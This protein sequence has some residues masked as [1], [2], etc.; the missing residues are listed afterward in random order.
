M[1][2][3]LIRQLLLIG[4]LAIV[5]IVVLQAYLVLKNYE[6]QDDE[7]HL[8]ASTALRTVAERIGSLY[9]V[10][11]PKKDLITR[12][13]SNL[14]AVNVNSEIDANVLEDYLIQEFEKH[15][16]ETDFEYAVYD[17]QSDS[18]VYGNYCNL[19]DTKGTDLPIRELP[20]YQEL[21]YYFVVRFPSRQSFLLNNMWQTIL[22]SAIALLAVL[23]FIYAIMIIMRQKQLTEL[24]KDFINN[25]THEFKTPISSIK[26]AS[27][28]LVNNTSIQEDPRLKKYTS[29]ISNQNK[30]LNNQVE[31]V[32]NIARLEKNQFE[33]NIVSLS[34]SKVMEKI[35]DTEK[36]KVEK[37]GGS[38]QF[39]NSVPQETS[40]SVDEL[41][42][43]NVISNIID[44]ATKYCT[45]E[46]E[47]IVRSSLDNQ[48]RISIAIKDNGIG[49]NEDEQKKIFNKFY[50]IS[51][52][53][54]HDVK[55]FGLGLYYVK[56]IAEAHGWKIDIISQ[57]AVGTTI[58]IN[59]PIL[60]NT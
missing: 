45:T 4:G 31:K 33:L 41:H 36:L 47:I 35:L 44:N 52:G 20:K 59:L 37:L 17:C 53:D 34:L 50:R 51:T 42:F 48:D 30:R 60:S 25:M 26:I 9:N 58:K 56:T 7:F 24:Q 18:L 1:P 39:Q 55:G 27:D 46:P 13:S 15:S 49:M 2:N 38:I 23:F 19:S 43:T 57:K 21:I 22:Y 28:Y 8:S 10:D 14:Y 54:L 11:L 3:N 29:I 6:L 40:I 5:G 32:L 16:L 12:R